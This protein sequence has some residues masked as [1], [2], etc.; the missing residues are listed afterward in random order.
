MDWNDVLIDEFIDLVETE[1]KELTPT[2]F[3]IERIGVFI[4]V[5]NDLTDYQLTKLI[6]EYSFLNTPP[7]FKQYK[8]PFKK[9]TFG[10]WISIEY[11]L[12]NTDFPLLEYEN[13]TRLLGIELRTDLAN[14]IVPIIDAYIHYRTKIIDSYPSVFG[15]SDNEEE[16][17]E[18]QIKTNNWGWQRLIY[19]LS[20][21][22]IINS[23]EVTD[24]PMILVF[25]WLAM[26]ASQKIE[27]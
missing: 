26:C 9:L 10:D 19:D 24:L 14:E 13:I 5:D 7:K 20:K 2:E 12:K 8:T 15:D 16:N 23:L 11:Y 3:L 25:N 6:S 4:E 27:P 21:G 18:P 22:N 17:E 1:R